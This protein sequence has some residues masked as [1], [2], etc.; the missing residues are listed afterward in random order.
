MASSPRYL[1]HK[2]QALHNHD[3]A[4]SLSPTKPQFPD[5]VITGSFYMA[6]HCVNAYAAKKG[7]KWKRY[8]RRAPFKISRHTQTLR[9]VRQKLGRSIFKDYIRLYQECWN[10]RYDPFYL[11]RISSSM[12]G[13]LFTIAKNFLNFL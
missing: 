4:Q 3:F 2:G 11:K 9:Y 13:N 8:P 1:A 10:A 5:W 6:L 7:W 12:A